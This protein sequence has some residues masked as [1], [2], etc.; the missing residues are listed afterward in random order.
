MKTDHLHISAL[1]IVLKIKVIPRPFYDSIK[2][3]KV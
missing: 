1:E 2:R 3:S